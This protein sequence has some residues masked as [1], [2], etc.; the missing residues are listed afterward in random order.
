MSGIA[1]GKLEQVDP[2]LLWTSE[3]VH[4]TPWLASNLPTLGEALGLE[5][6]LL[7]AESSVG[8]FACDIEARDINT[9]RKVII[10]N[11][12]EPT[13]HTHLGQLLTYA[14]G[15]DATVIVWI[16]PRVRE[17]HRQ[18][19]DF[20]N[21][22]TA[23]G[24]DFFAVALEVV[25][26]GASLPAVIFRLVASPNAWAKTVAVT[27][28]SAITSSRMLAY[29]E[30]FQGVIDEL[31]NVYHFTSAKAGLP[32]NWYSFSSGTKGLL[33]STSFTAKSQIRAELYIDVGDERNKLIFDYFEKLKVQLEQA[34]GEALSWE[35]LDNRRGS[36]IA[37]LR[38]NTTIEDVATHGPELQKWV[39]DQLLRIKGVF[40]PRLQS[41]LE[42]VATTSQIGE[43]SPEFS[44]SVPL[45]NEESA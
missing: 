44:E 43:S 26:I 19:I 16:S 40:R 32:Q 31:R 36:R 38:P 12:L 3:P 18:A 24:L 41:A 29:Q 34:M 15:L 4:F 33:Y 37:A 7:K 25:K 22:H 10:E 13:D 42:A 2:R 8:P 45:S 35:R 27:N 9:G 5:L 6:E 14:A 28:Q 21:R 20:L 23:E 1:L 39:I 30:F 11:Q 17:Q